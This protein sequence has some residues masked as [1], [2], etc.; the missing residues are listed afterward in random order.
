MAAGTL[1]TS[2]RTR[3]R[4]LAYRQNGGIHVT[5]LWRQDDDSLSVIVVDEAAGTILRLTAGRQNALNVFNHP[6]AYA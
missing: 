3:T 2:T 1:D 5:L 4:E 6:F